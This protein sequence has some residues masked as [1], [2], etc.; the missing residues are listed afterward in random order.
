MGLFDVLGD[1]ARDKIDSFKEDPAGNIERTVTRSINKFND[2]CEKKRS[3][4]I[5]TGEKKARTFSDEQ[6]RAY[7]RNADSSGNQFAQEIAQREM[8][9][10]GM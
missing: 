7:A 3:E 10:R 9:R 8:E 6:L 1:M 4:I 2:E 5:R